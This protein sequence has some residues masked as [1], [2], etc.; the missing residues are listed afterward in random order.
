M[1]AE[2]VV[3]TSD[4]CEPGYNACV[5]C[6]TEHGTTDPFE[7]ETIAVSLASRRRNARDRALKL[8]QAGLIAALKPKKVA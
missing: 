2:C 5:H 6:M 8:T 1:S 3:C 4:Y 7:L